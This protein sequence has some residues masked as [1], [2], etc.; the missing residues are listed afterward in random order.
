MEKQ[1]QIRTNAKRFGDSFGVYV[2]NSMEYKYFKEDQGPT[3]TIDGVVHEKDNNYH[4]MPKKFRYG[5]T[6]EKFVKQEDYNHGTFE[7]QERDAKVLTEKLSKNTR[8]DV[9]V[10][11]YEMI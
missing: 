8:G 10:R 1:F 6:A 9:W 2:F 11:L 7:M 5:F 4:K 3:V